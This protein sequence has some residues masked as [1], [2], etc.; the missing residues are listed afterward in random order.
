[1]V[2]FEAPADAMRKPWGG[3]I[4]VQ[5]IGVCGT[6]HWNA[7]RWYRD[8]QRTRLL[9]EIG[10]SGHLRSTYMSS[11]IRPP[12]LVQDAFQFDGNLAHAC[13]AFLGLDRV[14]ETGRPFMNCALRTSVMVVHRFLDWYCM[15]YDT[16]DT[17]LGALHDRMNPKF[18]DAVTDISS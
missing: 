8:D 4:D 12:V 11:A 6:G 2:M 3:N 16:N 14:P 5:Q 1:M 15:P 13:A 9:Q 7:R 18:A 10:Y 17:Q